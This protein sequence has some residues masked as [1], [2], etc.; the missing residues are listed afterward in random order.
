MPLYESDREVVQSELATFFEV[1]PQGTI[2]SNDENGAGYDLV[3]LGR[4]EAAKIDLD[5]VQDR[6]SSPNYARVRQS[7]RDVGF[8][9][10]L[11]LLSTYGGQAADLRPWLKHAPINR[12]RDLHLEYLAGLGLNHNEQEQVYSEMLSYRKFPEALF[13][14]REA[15]QKAL[16]QLIDRPQRK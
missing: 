4:A 15:Q 10:A 6:L 5:Q 14:G 13:A 8:R 16:W 7:L 11:A 12:D 1:F 3:L 2:W 9:S